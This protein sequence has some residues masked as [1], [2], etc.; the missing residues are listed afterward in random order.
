[1]EVLAL[2]TWAVVVANVVFWG[3]V[4]AATGYAVH[5]LPVAR[6][7]RD[8]WLLRARAVE[9]GGR[10]YERLRIRRWK[11]AVPEA[12]ALFAGG[13][14]KRQVPPAAAGGLGRFVVETRR[15]EL[16]HWLA[17]AAG[18]LAVLWNAPP[19][20]AVMVAYGVLA[21]LPCIAI[22][23]FNRQRAQRALARS[24]GSRSAGPRRRRSR[25]RGSSMP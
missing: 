9:R 15:A 2:P 13:V 16:G 25:T 11:D 10:V 6:L 24:N 19:G 14:S 21:N 22:Q 12:G 18:P 17:L 8:G 7:G 3:S 5:R 4:H 1:M 23:R 20:S